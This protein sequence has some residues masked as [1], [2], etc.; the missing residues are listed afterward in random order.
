VFQ[1]LSRPLIRR[2]LRP[3]LLAGIMLLIIAQIVAL[4]P[5]PLE[6]PPKSSNTVI[7]PE[8]LVPGN[9]QEKPPLAQGIP[10]D[11]VPDYGIEGFN[12]VSTQGDLKLWKL[13][14]K[15]AFLYNSLNL[16]HAKQV[17]AHL[18]D[19]E[20][21][22]TTV[23]GL[24]AK[25]FMNQR[26]LEVFGD[27]KTKFPDGFQLESEYLRYRPQQRRIDIPTQYAVH[28]LGLAEAGQP[29]EFNSH[30]LEYEMLAA[31]I[32][33]PQSVT[34][35][36][37]GSRIESDRCLILRD[38]SIAHFTMASHRKSDEAF[39]YVAQE[40]L[41]SRGRRAQ[42]NYGVSSQT[43]PQKSPQ[44]SERAGGQSPGLKNLILEDDVLIKDTEKKKD[45]KKKNSLRYA[46]GGR[47]EFDRK[48]DLIVLTQYPQVYQDLDTVTGEIIIVHRDTDIVEVEKSNAYSEGNSFE[49][50]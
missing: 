10:R 17:E 26:D 27:V 24:E 7:D 15:E 30:G 2:R 31:T 16:V 13:I 46:T 3:W 43:S 14:A 48:R 22:I 9:D 12:Y 32:V 39:V 6:G 21:Q 11:Q 25:Y 34:V 45:P 18:Y 40:T 37:D 41:L 23:T 44:K 28:G 50:E 5:S 19:T 1:T 35:L 49:Q 33:L 38:K 8:M 4:S 20:G 47:A 36:N 29:M 42:L